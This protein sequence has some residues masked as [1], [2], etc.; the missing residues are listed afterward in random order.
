[1]ETEDDKL[2]GN[3]GDRQEAAR[4]LVFLVDSGIIESLD[5]SSIRKSAEN[6]EQLPT[7]SGGKAIFA[8]KYVNGTFTTVA[9][10][11]RGD[12]PFIVWKDNSVDSPEVMCN[13]VSMKLQD[14]QNKDRLNYL[15][16]GRVEGSPYICA[17][18]EVALPC[19]DILFK[20]K[21]TDNPEEVLKDLMN[22]AVGRSSNPL[23]R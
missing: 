6:P 14:L 4:R 20:L 16:T 19:E 18:S 15:T 17:T 5:S 22:A 3:H 23:V 1:M 9:I 2:I 8:C 10:T 7:F 13:E 11:K 12:I 21:P